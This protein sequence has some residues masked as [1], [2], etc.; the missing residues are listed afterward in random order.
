MKIAKLNQQ[1]AKAIEQGQYVR[2]EEYGTKALKFEETSLSVEERI[3]TL[4][5]FGKL[6]TQTNKISKALTYYLQAE[7]LCQSFNAEKHLV[8]VYSLLGYFYKKQNLT[9]KSVQYFRQAY[10][11]QK[12]NNYQDNRYKIIA[13]LA[14]GYTV[15]EDYVQAQVFYEILIA[16]YRKKRQ[17][18]QEI[19]V[20]EQLAVIATITEN[21][22]KAIGYQSLLLKHFQKQKNSVRVSEIYNDLGFLYQ[23]KKDAPGALSYFNLSTE[24]TQQK[25]TKLP[26]SNKITL[27]VNTGVA[28]TNIESFSKA[29]KYFRQA[30]RMTEP[31]EIKQAEIYNYLGANYYLSGNNPQALN[32]VEKAIEIASSKKAWSILLISYDLLS[33]IYKAEENKKRARDYQNKYLEV[34]KKL[35][36][37]KQQLKRAASQNLKLMEQQEARI[38]RVLAEQRQLKELKDSQEKQ[39]KDL[40]LKNNLVKLQTKELALLKKAQELSLANAQRTQLEKVRQKQ[41]LL[42]SQ[43]KLREANLAK[44]K[45]Q[46]ALELERKEAEKKLQAKENQKQMALLTSQKKLQQQE[47]T[48]QKERA[49][50]AV[51]III[52]VVCILGL[53]VFMLFI[54]NRNRRKLKKQKAQ[55]EE[56]NFEITSQN[57]ELHQQ[58][59]EIMAQRDNIE[60]KNTQLNAQHH[61]IQQS[62][63]AALTIQR[64]VLPTI[65]KVNDLLP[66]HFILYRPKDV[67]SGDFYWLVKVENRTTL[68]VVDC[69]G[70]GV[71]GAFMAVM[72][73]SSLNSIVRDNKVKEPATILTLLNEEIEMLLSQKEKGYKNGMDMAIITWEEKQNQIEMVFA[74]AKRP[75]YLFAHNSNELQ[76]IKGSRHSIGSI[77]PVFTQNHLTLNKGDT[78]YL[79]SDGYCDQN[80]VNRKKFG[81]KRF[82]KLL[83]ECQDQK[84]EKQK[85]VI[86]QA[87]SDHMG[88]ASQRDDVIVVGLRF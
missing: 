56:Q 45:T 79:C 43:G 30:L 53:V 76:H 35:E 16:N 75:L 87:L 82:E 83:S 60:K 37:E 46:A 22:T 62:I 69:T 50:F 32:V 34:E 36:Q 5:L 58:Q 57:E 48:R 4:M 24:F 3:K 25:I 29:K 78:I 9:Q 11:I 7:N 33:R 47:I 18:K 66:E 21:Y 81:S 80:N 72:G 74:G 6:Y 26:Q 85:E 31:Q 59:E 84:M 86:D 51:G 41:A 10:K 71:P 68:A 54:T 23:R 65:K 14:N 64:A 49:K 55:I 28:Y 38:K 17:K 63:K 20:I 13:E 44:A 77:S 73:N 70:H 27:L 61:H 40:E 67:V 52:S 12:K 88:E 1:F 19:E 39:K 2:A 15:L 42:I 8:T